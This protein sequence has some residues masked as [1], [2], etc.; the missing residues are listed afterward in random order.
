MPL[1]AV[2]KKMFQVLDTFASY[3]LREKSTLVAIE[4][5]KLKYDVKNER[6]AEQLI[7]LYCSVFTPNKI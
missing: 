7:K 3:R 1:K 6:D 5:I 4:E 2:T